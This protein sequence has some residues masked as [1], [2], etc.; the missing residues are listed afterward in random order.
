MASSGWTAPAEAYRYRQ[1]SDGQ[2]ETFDWLL[3]VGDSLRLF[4]VSASE[5]HCTDLDASLQR[6]NFV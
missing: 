6:N 5:T 4:A 2:T 1:Q 3:A